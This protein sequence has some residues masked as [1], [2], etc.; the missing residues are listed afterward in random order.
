ML[1]DLLETLQQADAGPAA[2]HDIWVTLCEGI[3]LTEA[4]RV[5]PK[6]LAEFL[7]RRFQCKV[8]LRTTRSAI[9]AGT[10]LVG[11]QRVAADVKV[12]TAIDAGEMEATQPG[13]RIGVGPRIKNYPGLNDILRAFLVRGRCCCLRERAGGESGRMAASGSMTKG[14]GS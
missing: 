3:D 9:G 1:L 12:G 8:G 4:E 11:L 14:S 7:H 5:H 6:L 10:G 13:K 2:A